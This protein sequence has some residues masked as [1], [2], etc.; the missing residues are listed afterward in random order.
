MKDDEGTE[1]VDQWGTCLFM[2]EVWGLSLQQHK[3]RNKQLIQK[4]RRILERL[5][6][7]Q[8]GKQNTKQ[9]W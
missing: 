9:D 2:C 4:E 7:V 6:V 8:L 5:Q 3:Q 1:G